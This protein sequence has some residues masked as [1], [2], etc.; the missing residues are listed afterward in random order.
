MNKLGSLHPLQAKLHVWKYP[1]HPKRGYHLDADQ[2]SIEHLR[3]SLSKLVEQGG[4]FI[5][6]LSAPPSSITAGPRLG[7]HPKAFK[8]L[9][10]QIANDEN[11]TSKEPQFLE[12]Q[13]SLILVL[14]TAQARAFGAAL[15]EYRKGR[16]DF[17]W[18]QL[19]F[20]PYTRWSKQQSV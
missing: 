11:I 13:D 6:N 20:W 1:D 17:N 8:R 9:E 15:D 14:T 7:R 3:Q 18:G 4:R 2:E 16:W 12:Q 10:V 19:W 5:V